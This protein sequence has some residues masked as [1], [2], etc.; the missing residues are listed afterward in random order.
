MIMAGSTKGVSFH[1]AMLFVAERFGEAAWTELIAGMSAADQQALSG[2]IPIGWYELDLYMRV[3]VRLSAVYGA[4]HAQLLQDYGRFSAQQDL[5]TTHKLVL[6]FASPGTILNQTM[7]L[8]RR[9]H[10]TGTWSVVKSSKRA[11]GTLRD[12]GCVHEVLCCEML[13]YIGMVIS[14]G[15][16]DQAQV[17]HPECRAQGADSC[18]FVATW[19]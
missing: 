16:G 11:E 8:W 13:G 2:I 4:G 18:V 19:D 1:N 5:T 12:W 7:K 9:F 14:L 10:D 17:E 3:L 6:R 15:N